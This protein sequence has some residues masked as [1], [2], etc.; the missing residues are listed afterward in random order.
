MNPVRAFVG[1]SFT[2]DD[3]EIVGKFLKYFGQLSEVH[4]KFSWRH[5]ESAEPKILADK[6][7]QLIA[8]KNLFIGICTRKERAV[9]P[10]ALKKTVMPS[11]YLKAREE[12]F[13]W[14]TS[15]WI[16]QE[17]G[18]ARGR[19]LALILLI[20]EGLR[21]P[22]GLQGDIEYISFNRS[23]PE[24]A[25][26]K[27]LEM[28][29][30]LSPKVAPIVEG[31][32]DPRSS[33]REA[34]AQ[35]QATHDDQLT[36][37]QPGWS[38]RDYEF[39][40][41]HLFAMDDS[42]G[43]K[44]VSDAYLATEAGS[45]AA[46]KKSWEA[47]EEHVRLMFGK[48]GQLARLRQLSEESPQN[49]DVLTYLARAY[50]QYQQDNQ[51]AV[52]FESAANCIVATSKK[53]RILRDAAL[54]HQ[55]AG[56]SQ[57]A[58]LVVGKM[59]ALAAKENEG[60]LEVLRVEHKLA[61]ITGEDEVM[62]GSMERLL[63]IDPSD[64]ETRFSLAYKYSNLGN[65]GLALLHYT[66]ISYL[67]RSSM[68]WNNLGVAYDQLDLPAKSVE[69]YRKS[70]D[71]GETLAMSNLANK[72]I[73]AGFVSEAKKICDVA[74]S[75]ED[76]HKNIPKSV[77][78]LKDIPDEEEKKKEDLVKKARLVSE[79][80][81]DFGRGIVRLASATLASEW[82]GPDCALTVSFDGVSFKATGSYVRR[83][84]GLIA[85][86]ILSS[87]SPGTDD[88]VRYIIEYRGKAR[89]RVIV[90]TVS[91]YPDGEPPKAK[92]LMSEDDPKALM[93]VSDDGGEIRVLEQA[94]KGEP[95]FY[96]FK[97]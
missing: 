12:D 21:L 51:A 78:R 55:R 82:R 59:K 33:A 46:L 45:E 17:I 9:L 38:R 2:D 4:P 43:A 92:T 77:S 53:L 74:L 96:N 61:E 26:G 11:G 16:I 15:D 69:S 64:N 5:A 57:N 22:G 71:M 68:T 66:K 85:R 93:I 14:K 88:A 37:P 8:D 62:L 91:R 48:G 80:Y 1:H 30:A 50:E 18:L 70:E 35:E 52:V 6:V 29:T 3:A 10:S 60:E 44:K 39:A 79:F 32:S 27:I 54:A 41:M 19:N 34:P 73:R 67:D 58:L 65:E 63:E 20:E 25:Y 36:T 81:R 7:M 87:T 83:P 47:Y 49:S 76:Y 94:K 42:A 95:R 86:A 56:N 97:R 24:R 31:E 84:L 90:A 89:G 40:L 13:S 75:K 28:I 72:F 23:A